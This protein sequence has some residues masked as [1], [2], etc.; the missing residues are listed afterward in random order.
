MRIF[1]RVLMFLRSD[2]TVLKVSWWWILTLRNTAQEP[3]GAGL[4]RTAIRPTSYPVNIQPPPPS[5]IWTTPPNLFQFR[6]TFWSHESFGQLVGPRGLWISQTQG[7]YLHRTTQ[8]RQTK[9]NIYAISRIRT[10]DFGDQAMKV[11]ASERTATGPG[12]LY[13]HR[14]VTHVSKYGI[15]VTP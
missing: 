1:R 5:A 9:T 14:I 10:Q 2:C 7:L 15:V 8:K 11:C 4:Y 3:D 12:R 6:I 13:A